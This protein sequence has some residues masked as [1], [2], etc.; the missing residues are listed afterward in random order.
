MVSVVMLAMK[1]LPAGNATWKYG[2]KTVQGGASLLPSRRE[3]AGTKHEVPETIP[4]SSGASLGQYRA[5]PLELVT[6][7]LSLQ[8]CRHW[9]SILRSSCYR[10]LRADA[11][12]RA[13]TPCS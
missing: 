4:D 12:C 8:L 3:L 11:C 9:S 2:R 6:R 7:T 5:R 13:G 1:A 10:G